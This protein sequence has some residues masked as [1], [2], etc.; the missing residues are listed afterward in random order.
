MSVEAFQK[1]PASES[2]RLIEFEKAEVRPGIVSGTYFLVVCGNAPC[3]N[4]QVRLEPRVY[5]RQPEYWG[6]EV[7]GCLN[8]GICLTAL[9]PFMELIPLAGITGTKG[10][11]VI[12]ATDTKTFDIPPK[13]GSD[14]GISTTAN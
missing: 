6:I 8:G 3:M 1:L 4:M 9:R 13:L 10:I 11:E 12:G 7:V 2:C 14:Q 5:V